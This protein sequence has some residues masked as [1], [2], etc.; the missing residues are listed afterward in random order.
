MTWKSLFRSPLLHFFLLGG[1]IFAAYAIL[2]DTPPVS[3]RDS[4]VLA[5]QEAA[6]MVG[7]FEQTWG[8]PPTL[9]EMDGML[10]AW[11][12]EEA[13]VR[14]ATALG[15]DRGDPVIRQRLALKMRFLA[16]GA[17]AAPDVDDA[18][19]QAH[20]DANSDTFRRPPQ[21]AF[22]QV[23]VG[24][25]DGPALLAALKGGSDPAEVAGGGLLPMTVQMTPTPVIDRTFGTGFADRL[26]A[27]P[28]DNWQGPVDSAYGQH[29]V[30]VTGYTEGRIPALLEIRDQVEDNWRAARARESQDALTEALLARYSVELPSASDVLA[31]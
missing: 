20:L 25:D 14:E 9:V 8:R 16:E 19:L 26:I 28:P 24:P 18:T 15:L 21:L 23:P 1:C 2:D 6:R 31:R 22:Q 17:G 27:L 7:R 10:Q 13:Y 29:L 11:A 30:R 12:V 5:P 4:I 3:G